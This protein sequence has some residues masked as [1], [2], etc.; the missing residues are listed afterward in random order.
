MPSRPG[1]KQ[2][3]Q[4]AAA[5]FEV[6]ALCLLFEGGNDLVMNRSKLDLLVE[7]LLLITS[8]RLTLT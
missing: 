3:K 7:G 4:P 2:Q 8:L 5:F 1:C 6:G